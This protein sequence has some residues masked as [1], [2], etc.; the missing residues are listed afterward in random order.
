MILLMTL[1]T[2]GS[3]FLPFVV[4]RNKR[5]KGFIKDFIELV[6]VAL[7]A[8]LVIPDLVISAENTFNFYNPFLLAGICT[9]VFAL[10]VNNL[11]LS[12]MFGMFVFWGFDKII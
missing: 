8:A 12:V 2:Y 9:F 1:A 6:P 11:F 7:L 4:L 5:I 3:R 10:R